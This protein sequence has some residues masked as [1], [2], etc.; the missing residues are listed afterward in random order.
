MPS[1]EGIAVHMYEWHNIIV[2]LGEG[3]CMHV[4]HR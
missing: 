4:N 1:L 2:H 3:A